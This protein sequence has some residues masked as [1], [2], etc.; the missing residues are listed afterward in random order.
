MRNTQI[1]PSIVG[2]GEQNGFFLGEGG[3]PPAIYVKECDWSPHKPLQITGRRCT[4]GFLS[5]YI[6]RT[7]I[8]C[9][10]RSSFAL[11]QTLAY[12]KSAF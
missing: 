7:L 4:F 12:C 5:V 6:C 10:Q 8:E 9:D 11:G 2:F 1:F 3:G